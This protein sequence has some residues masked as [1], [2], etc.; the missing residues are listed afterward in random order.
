MADKFNV[1]TP[2]GSILPCEALSI[3]HGTHQLWLTRCCPPVVEQLTYDNSAMRSSSLCSGLKVHG[4][5]RRHERAKKER[6]EG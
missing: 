2:L 4:G 5:C 1:A 3:V 6:V